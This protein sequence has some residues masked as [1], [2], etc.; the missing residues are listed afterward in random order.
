LGMTKA[1]LPVALD[2]V[3]SGAKVKATG[4]GRVSLDVPRALERIAERSASALM[5][6]TDLPSTRAARPF[7]AS[8]ITLLRDVLG[9]D[10]ANAALHGNAA[11]YYRVP[12][13]AALP[14]SA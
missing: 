4:F 1:G 3:S 14:S 11:A 7:Q 8:D 13:P 2:L 6:G 10:L 12:A 9:Q 5:F